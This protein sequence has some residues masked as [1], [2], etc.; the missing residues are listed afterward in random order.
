VPE[1]VWTPDEAT[2]ERANVVRLM[3]RHGIDDY[4]ELVARSIDDPEWFWPAA[5][6]DMGIE[7]AERWREVVDDSR[8]PEWATWFIGGRVNIA[9][10]CV[11]RWAA[12]HAGETAAVF[13]GEDGARRELTFGEQSAQVTKLAEALVRLG[14]EPGDRVAIY[15]PMSPEV[16]IASHACAHIGAVQVPIFSGFAAPA[17]AQRL[18]ESEAKVAITVE[19]SLRRG[20]EIPM[21]A[22]LE[23]ARREAPSLEHVVLAPFAELLADCRGELEPLAVDSEHPYLLTYTSG[24]TGR[25]KGVLHVQGGFLVSIARE[26]CYQADARPGDVIHFATDMGWIMGPWTVVGGGAMGAAIVYAEGA[27]D[28]PPDRL[29]RLIEE[30]RV[31]ILGCSPTLIRAL[32]PRGEPQQD[33]SSLRIIVTTGEPWNPDPYR[34]LFERVGGSRCPII[35]CSGGTEVGACF[36]SPT[37]SVPIKE[38]SLGGP[39]LG[40][41]M[42]VVSDDGR[43]LVETGDVGELVCRK[44]FPGMTRGF[45]RDEERYLDTYWRRFPGIWTHGDWASVDEDGYWFLHGRSDDTLNVAGKRIGPAELESAAVAHPAVAEAAAVGVPHDVKGETAWVF[46]VLVPGREGC[47]SLAL[48]VKSTIAAELGK[49]FAPERVVF[50]AA[51][52][53]TRSAKIV[54]RAVRAAALGDDPGDLSSVENP[55]SVAEIAARL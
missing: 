10:N 47:E 45:W 26:V 32:I 1:V 41:A 27:P 19:S 51:L 29:W 17:V 46:C 21:L 44:P 35:N 8:G 36:L 20:R 2:L 18:T 14:V 54:R 11:H 9:W 50:V 30:E 24:T 33:L 7:F 55:E 38:C 34:W 15:L 37:P 25:P 12:E 42:D 22:T 28:W 23:E 6:E 13:R 3:R 48:E 49:A 43:S 31:T 39:A 53:K 52:P 16:A 5:I 4:R 40:M